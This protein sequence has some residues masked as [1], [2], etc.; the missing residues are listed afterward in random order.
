MRGRLCVAE[1]C[2]TLDLMPDV[3]SLPTAKATSRLNVAD[4]L[5]TIDR[6]LP[7]NI[8]LACPRKWSRR[9]VGF[10]RGESG[11]VYSTTTFAELDADAT[12]IA[13]GLAAWGVP[14]GARLALLVRPNIDFVALVFGLLRAG[15][16]IVLVDP[17]LGTRNMIR[18]LSEAKPEGFVAIS[19]AHAARIIR[20]RNF[21]RTMWNV[22][23]GKRWFWG[24][25]SVQQL[26]SLG[27]KTSSPSAN[28]N[29]Q[30][31]DPAAIIFTSGSTGPAKGVLYTH[32]MFDTQVSEIQNAYS[33][34][35]G[36]VDLSCFPL[37]ALFNSAMGVTTV[38][39]EMNFSRPAAADPAKIVRAANDWQVTQAFASPAVWR[40][41][42]K[43][44]QKHTLRIPSLRQ[45]FSC[46]APVP[47]KVLRSTLAF[48]GDGAQMHTPYG[49]TEC[50]PI[51]TIEAAEVIGDTAAQ[52][53]QGAGVCV[54]RKFDSIEWRIIRITDKPIASIDQLDEL[55]TGEIGE[56]IVR[57]AQVSPSYATRSEATSIAKIPSE[58]S[59][60]YSVLTTPGYSEG[61]FGLP[62]SPF[63][64]PPS[65]AWH[66]TGDVGYFDAQA[67]FW[68]CGRKSQRVV[69]ADGPLFTECVEAVVN[70]E[71][72]VERSAL[73]GI[74]PRGQQ[75][76]VIV[77]ERS[78]KRIIPGTPPILE[79]VQSKQQ[80]RQIR[81]ILYCN[82]LPVDI[83]HNA[84]INREKLALWATQQLP[85]MR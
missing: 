53:D 79:R 80:T 74:G 62:P 60:Q 63:P 35:S 48:A 68:Y 32:R 44:C 38:L 73:V 28:A 84:K 9:S 71:P 69:T 16:V 82:R 42:G 36:G 76:P 43:H 23:I 22:T 15:M 49:A 31:D 72:D 40:V 33:L 8:A 83:R 57:G 64:L 70:L 75:S 45:I 56:L 46:G 6:E 18:C 52:T 12:R 39:P 34:K 37:F 54:G 3:E 21:P 58:S 85:E 2:F 10:R 81:A 11:E 29:T 13:R 20:H 78:G 65:Y 59:T 27:D 77:A 51:A 47:T 14:P 7:K 50:L 1:T 61:Q 5:A 25:L 41:V 17:G 26:R 66:R 55:P 30:A 67:R 4:R 19:L 24:G